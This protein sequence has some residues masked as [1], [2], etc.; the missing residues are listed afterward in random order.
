MKPLEHLH[1][2]YIYSLFTEIPL[3]RAKTHFGRRLF[4]TI[5]HYL[6]ILVL[7]FCRNIT[8]AA[9]PIIPQEF[10][11]YFSC[12]YITILHIFK[13][14]NLL[15]SVVKHSVIRTQRKMEQR[16]LQGFHYGT[17]RRCVFCF[18]QRLFYRCGNS[19]GFLPH[20]RMGGPQQ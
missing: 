11:N 9:K 15:L 14:A 4:S 20:R 10:K 1:R 12:I 6:V 7:I 13:K 2:S 18:A 8:T 16:R 19:P 17:R 3:T 5:Q